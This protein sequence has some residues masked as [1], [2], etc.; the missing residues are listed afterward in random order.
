[1]AVHQEV[2]LL[3]TAERDD[4][5]EVLVA[6]QFQNALGVRTHGLLA[7]QQRRLVVQGFA[8]HRH[9]HRGNAQRIAVRVLQNVGRAGDVPPGVATRLERAAQAARREARR[10]RLTLDQGLAGE[11]GQR[12]PVGD[13]LEEAVMLLGGQPGHRVEDVGV[14]GGA[15]L[16][17]P[18]LHRRGDRIGDRRV[19]LL[20]LL[21]RG[22]HRLV[23]RLGQTRLH[24]GLGEHVRSEDLARR[25]AGDEADG[26]RLVGLDIDDRLESRR[27]SAQL[28]FLF[29]PR[30][31]RLV[32]GHVTGPR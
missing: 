26:R 31:P 3:G 29:H 6:E 23:D 32:C 1:M 11:F 2:L 21:D 5:L 14:V 10:V 15:L 27:V 20:A 22:D 18:V 28:T 4:V 13:R 24:F 12:L 9:E 16:E 8:G 19:Q 17:C 25:L 30:C 7:T